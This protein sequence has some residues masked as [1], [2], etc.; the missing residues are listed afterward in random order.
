MLNRGVL[1]YGFPGGRKEEKEALAM[2]FGSHGHRYYGR[3]CRGSTWMLAQ[4][5]ELA[6][7][8]PEPFLPGLPRM[9]N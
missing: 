6:G 9:W 5:N 4:Q 2:A 7:E 8:F 3:R 1:L